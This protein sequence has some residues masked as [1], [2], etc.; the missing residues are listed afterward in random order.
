M[1]HAPG[2]ESPAHPWMVQLTRD[3]ASENL[4]RSFRLSFSLPLLFFHF[5]S[6]VLCTNFAY[7][8]CTCTYTFPGRI[9]HLKRKFSAYALLFMFVCLAMPIAASFAATFSGS[10]VQLAETSSRVRFDRRI[11]RPANPATFNC[12]FQVFFFNNYYSHCFFL[13]R[14]YKI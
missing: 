5:S 2:K 11:S 9:F 8:T 12:P 14:F 3:T 1:K 7:N 4:P 13:Y 10:V 6:S